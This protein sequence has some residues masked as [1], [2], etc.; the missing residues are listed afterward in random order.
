MVKMK[1]Q[2]EGVTLVEALLVVAIASGIIY[3]S[4]QQY[5]SYKH[6][7]DIIQV[8]ANVN[9]I[10]QAMTSYYRANCYGQTNASQQMVAG[11]L[12]PL[13]TPPPS[14]SVPIDITAL[15]KT[16]GYL[17]TA[18]PFNPLVDSTGPGANGYVAQFNKA[19]TTRYECL[20]G[21]NA[22]GPSDPKCTKKTAVGTIVVWKAQVAIL[23]KDTAQAN[24]Y[25]KL[26]DGDCLSDYAGGIVTPCSS[27]GNTGKYVV[28]E[29]LPSSNSNT[30]SVSD[31]WETIPTVHQFTQ[32][33][34][35]DP[36][37]LLTPD[38]N[39][40]ATSNQYYLC[41]N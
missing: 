11:S 6:D 28:W 33:Y 5:Q 7:G 37:L 9:T 22:T 20:T 8:N 41:G 25:V 30:S 38:P 32:M 26:L 31:Y 18:M 14:T 39:G 40:P 12:N 13:Y 4:V 27:S 21:I 16:P 23:L 29:R 15:L 17:T 1:R 2:Y 3:L 10:F 35:T 24:Q 34:T 36:I 19:T